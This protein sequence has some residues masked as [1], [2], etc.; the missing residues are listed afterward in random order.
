M[1]IEKLRTESNDTSFVPAGAIFERLAR[2][3]RQA[4]VRKMTASANVAR[5]YRSRDNVDVTH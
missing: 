5:A 4:N 2:D 1:Q 3:L